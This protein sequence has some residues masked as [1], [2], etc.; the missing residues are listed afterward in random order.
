MA[1]VPVPRDLTKVK[2]KVVG[3]FTSRQAVCFSIALAVALPT[4]IMLNPVIGTELTVFVVMLVSAPFI[5]FAQYEK[6]GLTGEQYLKQ[7]YNFKFKKSAIRTYKNT[8][9]YE[10]IN[11]IAVLEKKYE[12][13]KELQ[14]EEKRQKTKD[15]K[16]NNKVVPEG[17]K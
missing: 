2:S 4:F 15:R 12:E 10:T 6:D 9:F 11:D 8:N 1:Y 5:F 3:N 16:K 13:I 17:V 14:A 7:V